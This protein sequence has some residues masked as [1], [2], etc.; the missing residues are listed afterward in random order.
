MRNDHVTILLAED[1][2][3]TVWAIRMNWQ[4]FHVRNPLP[5]A[6]TGE[7]ALK[8]VRELKPDLLVMD[9]GLPGMHGIEVLEQIRADPDER[10]RNTKVVVMT[11]SADK[12]DKDRCEALG[13]IVFIEKPMSVMAFA[14]AVAR[15]GYDWLLV[16]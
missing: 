11:G 4:D 5:V 9:L 10:I 1:D 12:R 3:H 15:A 13:V 7:E 6:W 14:E 16:H 2:P 8:R